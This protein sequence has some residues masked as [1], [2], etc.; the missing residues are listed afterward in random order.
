MGSNT[1]TD[2][3][4][5]KSVIERHPDG[6]L[7]APKKEGGLELVAEKSNALVLL[8][9]IAMKTRITNHPNS[10]NL[11]KG[12]AHVAGHRECGLEPKEYRVAADYLVA[13]G[14]V[15][16]FKKEETGANRGTVFE[17]IN[18]AIFDVNL[19]DKGEQS[20]EQSGDQGADAGRSRGDQGAIRIEG[21]ALH[22]PHEQRAKP[23][24]EPTGQELENLEHQKPESSKLRPAS[25]LSE[26]DSAED[27]IKQR[28][29]RIGFHG[30]ELMRVPEGIERPWITYAWLRDLYGELGSKMGENGRR[31]NWFDSFIGQWIARAHPPKGKPL[32]F[33]QVWDD[34]L[35]AHKEGRIKV[36]LGAHANDYW[37]QL[38]K[39]KQAV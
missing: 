29:A 14:Y 17:I 1:T 10:R 32:V 20:D 26:D 7:I 21:K 31:G 6:W 2:A 25:K 22:N 5:R 4:S 23:P 33:R 19:G 30:E 15:R 16:R 39:G 18:T 11:K 12:Q 24:F 38:G 27:Y 13:R 37:L 3:P 35:N 34:T 28:A 9:V 8:Y 36:S